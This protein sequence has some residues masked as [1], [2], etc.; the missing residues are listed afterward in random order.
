M[1]LIIVLSTDQ[2]NMCPH[3]PQ[4]H[5]LSFRVEFCGELVDLIEGDIT[6]YFPNLIDFVSIKLVEASS[7]ILAAFDDALQQKALEALRGKVVGGRKL[8]EVLLKAGVS[9]IHK[10]KI[11]L[12]DGGELPY[13]LAGW[14][15]GNAPLPFVLALT[16]AIPGQEPHQGQARSLLRRT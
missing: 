7:T 3:R 16:K 1:S 12:T 6:R 5:C 10:G 14:A 11:S 9:K 8:V 2:S 13:G 4:L 15:A